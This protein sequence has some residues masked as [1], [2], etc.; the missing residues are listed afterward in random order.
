MNICTVTILR[1]YS[2]FTFDLSQKAKKDECTTI[3]KYKIH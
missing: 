1:I 3:L 2:Y